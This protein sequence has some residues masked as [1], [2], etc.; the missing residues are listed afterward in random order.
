MTDA[1]GQSRAQDLAD[2][3]AAV[4]N[5]TDP[6]RRRVSIAALW[7][8]EGEHYVRSTE[9]RGYEALEQRVAGSHDKNVR[10][11]GHLFRAVGN[12]Q[13]LR[14]VVSFNWQMIR[15]DDNA[16]LAVGLEFLHVDEAGRILKDYQFIVA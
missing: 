3:Y 8:P 2:R 9:A 12:A 5:E 1:H 15:P 6:E 14:D 7:V 11:K 10:D 16:V 13:W 4:W